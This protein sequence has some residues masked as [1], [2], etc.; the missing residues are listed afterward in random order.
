MEFI[1]SCS[2]LVT[3]FT[4]TDAEKDKPI[5]APSTFFRIAQP[6]SGLLPS[7]LRLRIIQADDYFPCLHLLHT[8][9]LRTLEANVPDHQQPNFFS[10]LTALVHKTPLL[11]EIILAPGHFP[12]KS[13]QEILKFT[14]LRHLEL[15][16]VASTIDFTFL[17]DV[18]TLLN[19]ESF[20][21]D[22]RSCT[23]IARIPEE[24]PSNKTPPADSAEPAEVGSQAP[25]PSSDIDDS[26][27]KEDTTKVRSEALKPSSDIDR[28]GSSGSLL[29]PP[30]SRPSSPTIGI[31][32]D[33]EVDHEDSTISKAGGFS[34]LKKYHFVG[35]L[36]L[37][38]DMIMYIASSMLEDISITVN[39][40]E[41]KA[42]AKMREMREKAESVKR[43][44][45]FDRETDLQIVAM[46]KEA[47]E[48]G[49]SRKIPLRRQAILEKVESRWKE[50]DAQYRARRQPEDIPER[51]KLKAEKHTTILQT[52]SSRWSADLK[53]VKFS[54]LDMPSQPLP[55][56]PVL[57]KL[58]YGTVFCHPNLEILEFKQW[59]LDSLEDLLLSLKSSFP[60]KLKHLNL[61]IDDP[62]S[63]ISLSGLLDIAEACPMLESFHCCI[64]T[65]PPIPE[66]S[67][68]TNKALSHGLQSLFVANN[69]TSLWDFNQV[70]LVARH[71]Y[72]TFPRLQT[73]DCVEGPNSEQWVRIRD[74]VKMFQII[75]K[76][77]MYRFH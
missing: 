1:A 56:L 46:E 20:V 32:E 36:S 12:L 49:Y 73:I 8:P 44:Q 66:Y 25:Q 2:S 39:Q 5:I 50:Q 35:E 9:S 77:D 61:P 14:H 71:L 68:P 75:R 31:N 47:R 53:T 18:G 70:L 41:S 10:F 29:Y 27:I 15:R 16:D 19:L 4:L 22:A 37:L 45:E 69:P 60:K 63:A 59:K 21:L 33:E 38:Q 34:Q 67:S 58:V 74:Q 65:L 26:A 24:Q 51:K 3:E 62:G 64:D 23:Y 72:L 76:D 30:P 13:L 52:V 7:L 6:K 42:E 57:P 40:Q 11:E 28:D 48:T 17:Q 54:N 43:R 55:T